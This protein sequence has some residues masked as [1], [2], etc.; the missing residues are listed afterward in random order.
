MAQRKNSRK[1]GGGN[2]A[3]NR[4]TILSIVLIAV[5]VIAVLVYL[6][7]FGGLEKITKGLENENGT[8]DATPSEKTDENEDPGIISEEGVGTKNAFRYASVLSGKA[9]FALPEILDGACIE[10]HFIDVGQGDAIALMLPDG[11]RFLIDAG[12][13]TSVSNATRNK[14]DAYLTDDLSLGTIDYLLITHPDSDHVNMA[15]MILDD[16]EVKNVYFNSFYDKGSATYKTFTDKARSEPGANVYEV[17]SARTFVIENAG[18]RIDVYAP[19][20]GGFS[21]A[22]SKTNSMSILCVLSYGGRKVIFTGDAEVQTEEWFMSAVG[23]TELDVDVLKVG[24]H[25][26]RSCTSKGFVE[27]IKPEY[28]VISCGE[29][30]TYKHPHQETMNTLNE[31]GVATYRTDRHG[32]VAL[33]LDEDGDFLFLPQYL[34]S[35]ENN[36]KKRDDRMIRL[37]AAA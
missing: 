34:S 22:D 29:G 14:Y 36:S 2:T 6:I 25:G 9:D 26:S 37:E 33:Y 16:F 21:G 32:N 11:K 1:K 35:V 3:A 27:F 7:G 13:G 31:Y 8:P 10:V 24:H 23:G 20:N 5:L 30:N 15:S 4:K 12:S 28:A 19:G 17:T 18:Y